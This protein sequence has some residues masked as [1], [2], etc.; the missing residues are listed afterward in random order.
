MLSD[1]ASETLRPLVMTLRII[2][3]ALALGVTFFGIFAAVQNVGKPP[4]FGTK[5]NYLFLALAGS[6]F[7]A[8]FVVPRLLPKGGPV[9]PTDAAKYEPEDAA[10]IQAAFATIQTATIVG[11]ALF[12]GACFAIL[13]AYLQDAE[14]VHLA[15]SGIGL[16]C[17]LTS[18]IEQQIEDQ[19]QSQRDQQQFKS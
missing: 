18:R 9:Q 8:G 19:L 7:I 3:I 2:V 12:E 5:V 15:V 14:L 10:A 4:T 1:R 6:L 11:C 16:F 17:I 13:V